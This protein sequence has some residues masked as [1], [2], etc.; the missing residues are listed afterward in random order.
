MTTGDAATTTN[1]TVNATA[2]TRQKEINT[3]THRLA[4]KVSFRLPFPLS[5]PYLTY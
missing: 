2:N 4:K 1:T 5:S 3:H